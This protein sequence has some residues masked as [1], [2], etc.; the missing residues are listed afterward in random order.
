MEGAW[1]VQARQ[2]G[3]AVNCSMWCHKQ[4]H[5]TSTFPQKYRTTE[6]KERTQTYTGTFHTGCQLG[7]VGHTDKLR[8]ARAPGN[9]LFIYP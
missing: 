5:L 2:L 3:G 6:S 1:Q 7:R 4:A 8:D 9:F